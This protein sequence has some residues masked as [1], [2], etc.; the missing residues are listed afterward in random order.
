MVIEETQSNS[1]EVSARLYSVGQITL[2]TFLGAPVAGCLLLDRNYRALGRSA[3]A[4]Q[5]LAAG[6]VSTILLVLIGFRLPENFPNMALPVAYCV[7]MRQ[8]AKYLHG[9]ALSDHLNSGGRKGSWV[10][11]VVVGLGGLIIIFGLT[12]G[13]LMA[14]NA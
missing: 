5:S 7:G 9:E 3:A 11:T 1:S 12:V 14:L 13:L 8:L 2:A 10:I 4:W 6:V